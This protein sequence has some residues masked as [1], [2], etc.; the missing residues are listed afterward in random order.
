MW[1]PAVAVKLV[2]GC[3]CLKVPSLLT[4]NLILSLDKCVTVVLA[5]REVTILLCVHVRLD[6]SQLSHKY[7]YI[8]VQQTP[9]YHVNPERYPQK[10]KWKYPWHWSWGKAPSK[11]NI[12]SE[13][14]LLVAS[15]HQVLEG[16]VDSMKHDFL[17]TEISVSM[18]RSEMWRSY[19]YFFRGPLLYGQLLQ[20]HLLNWRKHSSQHSF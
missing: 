18:V 15:A 6:I 8:Y 4:S 12:L 14:L 17:S 9:G 16:I 2:T 3:L 20:Y 1:W 19:S 11:T 10:R 13:V 7:I 5:K